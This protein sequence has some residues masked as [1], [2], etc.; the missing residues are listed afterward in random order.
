MSEPK[1]DHYQGLDGTPA[2]GIALRGQAD[3]IDDGGEHAV[4][5][6]WSYNGITATLDGKVVGV[7]V[8]IDQQK[9]IRRI[10]LQLGYVL[11]EFRGRGIYSALWK[12]LVAKAQEMKCP[13]IQ[14]AAAFNNHRMRD[15]AKA[16]GRVEFAVNLRFDV[17]EAAQS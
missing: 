13:Q 7:I 3:C 1:I 2:V 14:S 12:A 6:H 5:L 4:G 10:W 11:P 8:W 16:Q 15:V 9:E 17:P